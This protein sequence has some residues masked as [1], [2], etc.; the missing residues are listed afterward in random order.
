MTPTPPPEPM[1]EERLAEIERDSIWIV[2][3][4][5]NELIAEV[6]RL[7]AENARLRA[8]VSRVIYDDFIST[9]EECDHDA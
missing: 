5:F 2:N 9:Q 8:Q 3:R 4:W 7:R 1:S 6:R